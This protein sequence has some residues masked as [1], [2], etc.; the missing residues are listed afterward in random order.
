A[1]ESIGD[2]GETPRIE[3]DVA[4]H[5]VVVGAPSPVPGPVPDDPQP[6]PEPEPGDFAELVAES[7]RLARAVDDAATASG[8]AVVIRATS[9]SIGQACDAGQ[10][11]GLDE[12]KR[13]M[14][15]SIEAR[16]FVRQ[17]SSLD[18]DWLSGWRRPAN[19]A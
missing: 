16:L 13:Q 4:T 14:V 8:L 17:G 15:A 10:C 3:I 12:A 18:A 19:A 6:D 11:P 1:A 9:Q 2:E 7:Q 5:T